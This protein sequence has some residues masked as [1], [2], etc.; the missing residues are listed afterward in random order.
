MSTTFEK[1]SPFANPTWQVMAFLT[2]GLAGKDHVTITASKKGLT[3]KIGK[4]LKCSGK[5][6]HELCVNYEQE[7]KRCAALVEKMKLA[8]KKLDARPQ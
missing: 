2:L 7:M 8:V 3:L 6:A 1:F 5:D 4:W